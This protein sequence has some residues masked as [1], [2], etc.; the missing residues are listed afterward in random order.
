M[1]F[2]LLVVLQYM[3]IENSLCSKIQAAMM[4]GI[5]HMGTEVMNG[6]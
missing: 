2:L 1:T 5:S 4:T 6:F 3:L